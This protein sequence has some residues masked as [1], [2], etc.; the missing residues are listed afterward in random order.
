MTS[1]VIEKMIKEVAEETRLQSI[2]TLHRTMGLSYERLFDVLDIPDA[3][4]PRYLDRLQNKEL[5]EDE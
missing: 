4:R 2:I 1:R 3:D 5:Q